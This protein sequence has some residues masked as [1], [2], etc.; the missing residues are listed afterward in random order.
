MD[1]EERLEAR[2]EQARID[3]EHAATRQAEAD[4]GLAA[5]RRVEAALAR[6]DA[7][8]AADAAVE[9]HRTHALHERLAGHL[10]R[11]RVALGRAARAERRHERA[12][13]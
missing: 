4:A 11:A 8:A 3:A 12:R 9:L 7:E 6:G 2:R 1:D 10:E 5:A 13:R